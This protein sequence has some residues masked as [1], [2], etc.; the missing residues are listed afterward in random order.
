MAASDCTKAPA[1]QTVLKPPM[2]RKVLASAGVAA[3]VLGNRSRVEIL[4]LRDARMIVSTA[5]ACSPSLPRPARRR[6]AS[7]VPRPGSS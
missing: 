4:D 6:P 5:Q 7:A 2:S 3:F 1:E